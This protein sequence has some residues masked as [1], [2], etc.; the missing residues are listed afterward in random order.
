VI[1]GELSM[2]ILRIAQL[3]GVSPAT[4]SRVFNQPEKVSEA[5]RLR[6]LEQAQKQGYRPNA[7]ART[8]RTQ[9]SHM[10]GVLLPTLLNPVFAECL[11]G[12]ADTALA[13]GYGIMPIASGYDRVQE[14]SSVRRLLAQNV[15]GLIMILTDPQEHPLIEELLALK[16]P[17]VLA[18]NQHPDYCCVSVD[19]ARE[20]AAVVARLHHQGHTRISM[21]S[22]QL[23]ASDRAQ[24]RYEGY[25]RGMANEGLR[26]Q[27]LIEVP[28]MS[29]D[30]AALDE[31]LSD[32]V[33]RPTALICSNDL[34]ALRCIRRIVCTGLSVPNDIS[35]V[36][37]DGIEVGAQITPMLSTVVQPS[38]RIGVEAVLCLVKQI[39]GEDFSDSTSRV[40]SCS[41]R[42]GETVRTLQKP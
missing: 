3:T 40:L 24:A 18:Y 16:L 39:K 37:F 13:E 2:S 22:G 41:F 1:G 27:A 26:A 34:L 6:V 7:A 33:Q 5:T 32:S 11:E 15:E 35:V 8:L 42:E 38:Q 36:G 9:R 31:A 19:N 23:S 20:V 28:F 25:L 4:V 10:I 21:L 29:Q 12:V 14:I 17:F 30:M